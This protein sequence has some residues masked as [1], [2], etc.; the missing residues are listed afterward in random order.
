[1]LNLNKLFENFKKNN[2]KSNINNNGGYGYNYLIDSHL[3]KSTV[4]NGYIINTKI[5]E[6]VTK[7]VL[8]NHLKSINQ[9]Y[10]NIINKAYFENCDFT[11]IFS[12]NCLICV[13]NP[14]LF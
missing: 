3:K 8:K 9:I 12:E 13:I 7:T 14:S 11:S 4:E 2:T 5:G 1:M 10:N 6:L